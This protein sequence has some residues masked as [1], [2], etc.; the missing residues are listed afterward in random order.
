MAFS[1]HGQVQDGGFGLGSLVAHDLAD[2]DS[3]YARGPERALM[4][5]LLFDGI[6]AYMS[7]AECNGRLQRSRFREAFNW[8]HAQGNE[9]VFSFENVCEG[10]GIDVNF[11]RYGLLNAFN[12]KREWKKARRNF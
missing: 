12:S 10:L 2:G 3:G 4:S 8:V 7:Y 9:Y 1:E 11:L 6:Q 5:A